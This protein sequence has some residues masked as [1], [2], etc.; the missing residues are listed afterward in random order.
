MKESE[1]KQF[2]RLIMD[3]LGFQVRDIPTADGKHGQTPDF[4]FIQADELSLVELK[5]RDGTWNFDLERDNALDDEQV[6]TQSQSTGYHN[7]ISS[8]VRVGA[9]QLRKFE[10]KEHQFRLLWFHAHGQFAELARDR[11]KTTLMGHQNVFHIFDPHRQW[12]AYY[13]HYSE[14]VSQRDVLDGTILSC[15]N[16]GQLSVQLCVNMWSPRYPSLMKSRIVEAFKPD[17]LCDPLALEASGE[18]MIADCNHPRSDVYGVFRYLEAKYGVRPL[19][20]I[21]MM[22]HVFSVKAPIDDVG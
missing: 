5:M 16:D 3:Q 1:G 13:F 7:N 17:N 20:F 22:Q 6:M 4:E 11:V 21:Q 15:R 19:W 18:V 2:V 14:F 12:M 8:I 9:D 10:Q